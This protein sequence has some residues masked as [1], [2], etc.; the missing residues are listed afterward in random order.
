MQIPLISGIT[1]V[2]KT[3]QYPVPTVD[4]IMPKLCGATQFTKLDVALVTEMFILP[5]NGKP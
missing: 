2:M 4:D 1:T 5:R 3:D